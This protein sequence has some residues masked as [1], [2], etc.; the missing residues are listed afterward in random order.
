V[1]HMF[2]VLLA[3]PATAVAVAAPAAADEDSYLQR[4]QPRLT[5]LSAEQLLSEGNKVCIA[6]KAGMKSVDA[7]QMVQ[8]D[9]AASVPAAS[10][11]VSAAVVELD[12]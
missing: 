4:L 8:N 3:V 1:V 9:L 6:S 10:D 12:C 11:I 5:F 7:V 2:R